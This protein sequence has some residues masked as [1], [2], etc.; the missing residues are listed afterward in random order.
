M[1]SVPF[2]HY[3]APLL[4]LPRDLAASLLEAC[5]DDIEM[6]ADMYTKVCEEERFKMNEIDEAIEKLQVKTVH[7]TGMT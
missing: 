6:A 1:S 5:G 7:C 4:Q 3:V 2:H